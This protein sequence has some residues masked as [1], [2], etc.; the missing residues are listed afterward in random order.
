MA[1]YILDDLKDLLSSG[2][3]TTTLYREFMPPSPDDAILLRETGGYPAHRA[4]PGNAARGG[5]VGSGQIVVERVTVQI[6]RRSPSA[7][8]A[9]AEMNYIYRFLDG[10]G[11][12]DINGTRYNHIMAL[13]P[14]FPLPADESGRSLRVLN[15]LVEKALSTSTST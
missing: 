5:G 13:Q 2:G 6:T 9:I 4:M 14:P 7:Q 8:R 1:S 10:A 15:F 11:D 12:R 3:V